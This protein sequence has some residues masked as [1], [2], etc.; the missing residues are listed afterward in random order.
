MLLVPGTFGVLRLNSFFS[1]LSQ[2]FFINSKM[3]K[4]TEFFRNNY[5]KRFRYHYG[6][7]STLNT[8]LLTHP[9]FRFSAAHQFQ[10]LLYANFDA[11][12]LK[13]LFLL[14]HRH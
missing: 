13:L 14:P 7:Q 10:V 12:I 6:K 2:V 8:Q 4:F 3:N 9:A 11:T 1:M 5:Y